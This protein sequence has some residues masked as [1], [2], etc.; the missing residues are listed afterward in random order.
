[1]SAN[2][3][4]FHKGA[5]VDNKLT[6]RRLNMAAPCRKTDPFAEQEK[7]SVLRRLVY[8]FPKYSCVYFNRNTA[9]VVLMKDVFRFLHDVADARCPK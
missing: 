5:A 1:M 6:M 2:D 4:N 9:F 3:G 7:T 8:K